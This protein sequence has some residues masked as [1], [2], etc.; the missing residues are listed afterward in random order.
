MGS[1]DGL[2]KSVIICVLILGLLLEHQAVQVDARQSCCSSTEGRRCYLRCRLTVEACLEECGCII[3][4]GSTCPS[5]FPYPPLAADSRKE[6][7]GDA[8]VAA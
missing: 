6:N 7:S 4:S 8:V 5:A 1:N 3:I 2:I